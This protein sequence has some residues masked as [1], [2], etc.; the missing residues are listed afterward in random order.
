MELVAEQLSADVQGIEVHESRFAEGDIGELRLYVDHDLTERELIILEEAI[1][2]QGVLLLAPVTQ[3][4]R[5]VV[6]KFRKAIAPLLIIGG[7]VTAVVTGL[8]G[9]QIFQASQ[10]GVP[11]W[12]W[13]VAAAALLYLF[14]ASDTGKKTTDVAL[15]AASRGV[16]RR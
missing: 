16:I 15:L 12:V 13:G 2:S 9:W 4:A 14:F 1:R 8:V 7:A 3:D 5:V 11:V 6:I 10:F